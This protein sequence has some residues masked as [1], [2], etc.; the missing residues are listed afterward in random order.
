MDL[1][2]A[3]L[4]AKMKMISK[5]IIVMDDNYG[6][7]AGVILGF[8]F[9]IPMGIEHGSIWWFVGSILAGGFFGMLFC[10]SK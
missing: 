7:L 6:C 2:K 3:I 8:F 1:M 4:K 10:N 5:N 9:G